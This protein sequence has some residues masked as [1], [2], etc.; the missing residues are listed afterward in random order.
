EEER[1][2]DA[3]LFS[4]TA[5]RF[6]DGEDMPLVEARLERAPAVARGAEG[7]AL[8]GDRRVG[9]L[10]VVRRDELA[11]IHE[12]RSGGRLSGERMGLVAQSVSLGSKL[13]PGS[14]VA[15]P[16][17]EARRLG[18]RGCYRVLVGLRDLLGLALARR[19][20][21]EVEAALEPAEEE[22]ARA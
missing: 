19:E 15:G 4:V 18:A 6:G 17:A 16:C 11:H 9:P 3:L 2:V 22:E 1:T 13:A 20:V 10:R 14:E 5:D 7:D 8:L 21:A 12:E